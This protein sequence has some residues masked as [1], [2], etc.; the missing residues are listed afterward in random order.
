LLLRPQYDR[1][2]TVP[3]SNN[4]E[5]AYFGGILAWRNAA[6]VSADMAGQFAPEVAVIGEQRVNSRLPLS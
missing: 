5:L 3:P 6:N 4:V 1:S 2:Q